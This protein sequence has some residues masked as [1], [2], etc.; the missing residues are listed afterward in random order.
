ME[1]I[2]LKKLCEE[3]NIDLAN[4]LSKRAFIEDEKLI[5][6]IRSS[7]YYFEQI[8]NPSERVQLAAVKLNGHLIKYINN[9]S[10][11]VQLAA[12]NRHAD[13]IKYIRNA[14][15]QVQLAAVKK[16]GQVIEYIKNPS[17]EVQLVAIKNNYSSLFVFKV[18]PC[19]AAVKLAFEKDTSILERLPI[20]WLD[21]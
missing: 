16:D 19:I 12:I 10:E 9:P 18:I 17:E 14:S 5:S 3:L 7:E 2:N 21:N 6:R 8:K 1:K 11:E 15:E 13:A 4:V 20:E